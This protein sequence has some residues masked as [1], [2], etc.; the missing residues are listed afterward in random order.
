MDFIN[1]LIDSY[2]SYLA[3]NAWMVPLAAFL[4]PVIEALI[5]SL[6]LT[7]LVIVNL[8]AMSAAFGATTGTILT[9]ILSVL[10]SFSGMFAI[11]LLI[12]LAFGRRFAAKIEASP[13]GQRFVNIAAGGNTGIILSLMCN[14]L[15]PGSIMNYVLA[16]TKIRVPRYI[17]LT[18]VSRVAIVVFIVF[19]GS[20][21]NIQEHPLNALWLF[22]GYG[23]FFG[24]GWLYKKYVVKKKPKTE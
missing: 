13:F 11:F 2:Q 7:S 8:G 21:F 22:L 17:F 20:V 10:G 19:L 14:P 1:Q 9:V 15:L 18:G 5:P 6:P 12:R 4:L 16:F 3:A 24:L 23:L